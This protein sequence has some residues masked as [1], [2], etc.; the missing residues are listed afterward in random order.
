MSKLQ[1]ALSTHADDSTQTTAPIN[2]N[3]G[4]TVIDPN[5]NAI[6]D[7]S[8]QQVGSGGNFSSDFRS[9]IDMGD[10]KMPYLRVAQSLS[11]EVADGRAKSGQ[12]VLLGADPVEE[13]DVVFL[14]M[15]KK[16]TMRDAD[17]GK[18][19]LC[20]SQDSIIGKGTPGGICANCPFADFVKGRAPACTFAYSYRAFSL[21]HNQPVLMD[22]QKTS[23]GAA[24]DLNFFLAKHGTKQFVVN[25][26]T[27]GKTGPK[28]AYFVPKFVA[29]DLSEDE[30]EQME[31]GLSNL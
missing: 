30:I 26:T 28:G 10:I 16:R 29:R 17:N 27:E 14:A 31:I 2:V 24:K 12:L 18:I 11:K 3:T 8:E 13:A 23:M 7:M 19:V 6:T 21:T 1:D 5:G 15:Q 25:I 9:M 20:S 22:L 4:M